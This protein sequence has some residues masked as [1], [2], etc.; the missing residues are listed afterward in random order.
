MDALSEAVLWLHELM[1]MHRRSILTWSQIS[2]FSDTWLVRTAPI[3]IAIVPIAAQVFSKVQNTVSVLLL[4]N[5][6]QINLKLPFSW[7]IF[8]FASLTASA[9]AL[10]SAWKC[11]AI[12]RDHKDFREFRDAGK[13]ADEL[14][15]SLKNAVAM[16]VEPDDW[17]DLVS[18]FL[19]HWSRSNPGIKFEDGAPQGLKQLVSINEK[20]G[21]YTPFDREEFRTMLLM[22]KSIL[23]EISNTDPELDRNFWV[24]RRSLEFTR[25]GS[26]LVASLLIAI[27]VAAYGVVLLQNVWTVI[28]FVSQPVAAA[29]L[30]PV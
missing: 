5:H 23:D 17:T 1:R 26:R 4:S 29:S 28:T 27:S 3:W 16:G 13:G 9:A 21:F 20:I 15:D 12:I 10:V 19:M 22:I 7:Q 24:V 6:W 25:T 8:F 2:K 14:R 18:H 11:P 30:P